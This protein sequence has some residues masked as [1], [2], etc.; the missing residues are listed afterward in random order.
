MMKGSE[1]SFAGTLHFPM[2]NSSLFF[3]YEVGWCYANTVEENKKW[4]GWQ[5]KEGKEV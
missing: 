2:P 1:I 4:E 5:W 3:I